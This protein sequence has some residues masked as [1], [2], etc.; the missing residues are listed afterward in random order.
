MIEF[1]KKLFKLKKEG[2]NNFLSPPF[3]NLTGGIDNIPPFNKSLFLISIKK[4]NKKN[5][6]HFP[7]EL[8]K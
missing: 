8:L 1:I 7:S 3:K 4:T 2:E 6:L 5:K